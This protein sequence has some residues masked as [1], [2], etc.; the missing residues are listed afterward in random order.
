[1]K[2]AKL[3]SKHLTFLNKEGDPTY[4][5]DE[6]ELRAFIDDP[7]GKKK[8]ERE[9][10]LKSSYFNPV[11]RKFDDSYLNNIHIIEPPTQQEMARANFLNNFYTS[12][13]DDEVNNTFY[14]EKFNQKGKEY[15]K[16]TG[17]FDWDKRDNEEDAGRPRKPTLMGAANKILQF[18]ENVPN[19]NDLKRDKLP[20]VKIPNI[21]YS[22]DRQSRL[23]DES[24]LLERFQSL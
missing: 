17:N 13:V 18:V 12:G 2:T 16:S 4:H 23:G 15:N 8:R 7:F 10:A 6:A 1:M 24:K 5:I 20:S 3:S 9:A 14:N 22:T 19:Q 11:A 21:Y